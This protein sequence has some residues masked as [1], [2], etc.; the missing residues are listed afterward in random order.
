MQ[1]THTH[2]THSYT[3]TKTHHDTLSHTYE[4]IS[5]A[6]SRPIYYCTTFYTHTHSLI[7]LY[8]W[9]VFLISVIQSY[10]NDMNGL[11]AAAAITTLFR[12]VHSAMSV[13]FCARV[14][15]HV[16]VS[17][18]VCASCR[19]CVIKR[20]RM[21]SGFFFFFFSA[22]VGGWREKGRARG[23]WGK[24]AWTCKRKMQDVC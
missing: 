23:R 13:P 21:S 15:V 10:Y 19:L 24:C 14:C 17:V 18:C 2:H 20:G 12:L 16:C 3:L 22:Q 6:P 4:D 11:A 9:C 7:P 8:S 1:N 5:S